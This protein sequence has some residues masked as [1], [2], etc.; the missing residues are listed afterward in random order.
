MRR[1]IE[2]R[3]LAWKE[4]AGGRAPL[5]LRG[6]RHVGKTRILKEFGEKHYKN[7]VYVDFENNFTAARYF[8][9]RANLKRLIWALET[10]TQSVITPGETLIILDE[11]QACTRALPALKNFCR[12]R[13]AYHIIAAGSLL[14][15][16]EARLETPLPAG[17]T[18]SATLHPLDFEEFLWE[19]GE[20][21]MAGEIRA[22]YA[23]MSPMP[24]ALHARAIELYR[25]YLAVGGMPDCVSAFA[26]GKVILTIPAIQHDIVNSYTADM[27][28]Y[29]KH[30]EAVKLRACYDSIPEQLTK[31][32]RKFQYT[33]VQRGGSAALF[34]EAIGYL[35]QSCVTLKSGRM[36]LAAGS[37]RIIEDPSS[38]KLYLNDAGLFTLRAG[39]S[40]Q[41]IMSGEASVF[42]DAAAENYIA[43]SLAA[44]GHR[45]F[46]W[47]STH[48]AEIDFALQKDGD[49]IGVE[50]KRSTRA[51]SKGLRGFIQKCSP[52]Y[53][54][55]FSERNFGTEKGVRAVPH[56]AAFCV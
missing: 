35:A 20:N 21:H 28:K 47:T 22:H 42:M 52:A 19:L 12:G 17:R 25:Y 13:P 50:V 3:L 44:G 7:T 6:A 24:E 1:K 34:G 48:T 5:L 10:V 4:S 31:E 15:V 32:N 9:E 29:S 40:Q 18:E 46:H 54:I 43:Q 30:A 41:A 53:I 38:F 45:L 36:N 23:E 33:V 11:I 14:G 55:R 56:Y 49:I 37:A 27:A 39:I 26:G 8:D 2:A 51:R 16:A